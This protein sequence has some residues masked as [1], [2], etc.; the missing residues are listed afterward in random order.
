MMSRP[1][2]FARLGCALVV[3]LSAI[4]ITSE[5]VAFRMIQNAATGR[6]TSGTP[7]T[8]GNPGGFLHWTNSNTIDWRLNTAGQGSNKA[9]AIQSALSAW[10]NVAN[11]NL[12]PVYA[13][14]TTAG[15]ETDG[16]NTVL[17]AEGNGCTVNCLALTALVVQA[18]QVIIESD[19]TFNSTYTW[20]ID[21]THQDTEAVAAH[22]FGHTLGIHH[23]ESLI[24]PYPTMRTPYF[25]QN[26]RSLEPD[27]HSALQCA[28]N[29]YPIPLP[30]SIPTNLRS[31]PPGPF[32]ASNYTILWNDSIG[33][34]THYRLERD[35][36]TG[37]AAPNFLV[38]TISAPSTSQ[39][40]TQGLAER[41]FYFRVRACNG[42][43]C[44]G[45]SSIIS[46]TVDGTDDP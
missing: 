41:T 18:G 1:K 46:R 6:L 43:N 17:W 26:G 10:N 4:A 25:G 22:E 29:Q 23:T 12:S 24:T 30:P 5:S 38:F 11:A 13:G 44:S 45:W 32:I 21:G 15:W 9:A 8:C 31:N 37:F 28:E 2:K 36:D 34:V 20:N 39:A 27:D 40:F 14:T 42:A 7:V 33:T 35:M 3:A 19:V 16:V